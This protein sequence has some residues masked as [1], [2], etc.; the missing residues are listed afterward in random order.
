MARFYAED[1]IDDSKQIIA[2]RFMSVQP[3]G[4]MRRLHTNLASVHKP[5]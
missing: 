1:E 3:Q 4:N 2:I 5:S